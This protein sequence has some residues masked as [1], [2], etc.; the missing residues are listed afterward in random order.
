MAT[1]LLIDDDPAVRQMLDMLFSET[2]ECH[3]ADRAEQALQL[4]E[5]QK[6]DLVITDISMP[7]LGGIE[8]LKLIRQRHLTTPVIVITGRADQYK[9]TAIALGA[10]AFF[11]KPFS[12][13]DLEHSVSNAITGRLQLARQTS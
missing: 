3:T 2:H 8:I 5:F 13:V 7:G 12:L 1:L 4:L 6:Y 10:F 11:A 9:D